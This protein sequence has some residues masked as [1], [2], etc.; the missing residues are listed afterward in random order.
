MV[1]PSTYVYFETKRESHEVITTSFRPI[2][3]SS[4][5]LAEDWLRNKFEALAIVFRWALFSSVLSYL[6]SVLLMKASLMISHYSMTRSMDWKRAVDSM[7]STLLMTRT[8]SEV[9]VMES[10]LLILSRWRISVESLSMIHV[11][12]AQDW[13]WRMF[14]RDIDIFIEDQNRCDDHLSL[15]SPCA[16][17]DWMPK[18][19]I[20][21]QFNS[22]RRTS[23]FRIINSSSRP[24]FS[25]S[26]HPTIDHN[27]HVHLLPVS[28]LVK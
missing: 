11:N 26:D 10:D 8:R 22:S 7:N 24:F 17:E 3:L 5:R 6:F 13:S 15:R 2:V 27:G 21:K 23:Q 19:Q 14:S 9:D 28:G 25:V 18:R 12:G 4:E 1:S 20:S 16:D